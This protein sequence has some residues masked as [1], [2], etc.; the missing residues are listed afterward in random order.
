MSTEEFA[1]ASPI[2][3]SASGRALPSPRAARGFLLIAIAF[4]LFAATIGL[5]VMTKWAVLQNSD[6][7]IDSQ[8]EAWGTSSE[9]LG[10]WALAWQHLG[11]PPVSV[12]LVALFVGGLLVAKRFGWALFVLASA[13][14]GVLIAGVIKAV[15]DRPR[16]VW[17][18]PLYVETGGSFPSG[19]SMVGIY[20]W[21]VAG[22]VLIYVVKRPIGTWLGWILIVVG[23]SFAPSRL[24]L[25]VHWPSDVVAGWL[26]ATG[27]VLVV[28]AVALTIAYRRQRVGPQPEKGETNY[29]P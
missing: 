22:I 21:A 24:V 2:H 13:F 29:T 26:L 11:S 28:S 25:G 16:P 18:D 3:I 7:S 10:D 14:G 12:V 27:W 5:A 8:T 6:L 17:T 4:W 19:H 1:P 9:I 15:V 20:G 23:I